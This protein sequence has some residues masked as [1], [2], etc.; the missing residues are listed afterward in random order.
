MSAGIGS[1]LGLYEI[2]AL[3]GKGGMGEVYRGRDT[4]LKRDVAIKILP[5]EFSRDPDRVGRFQREA[6]VLASLNHPNIAAIYDLQEAENSRFL[7]LELVEGET[8][9]ERIRR[10]PLPVDEALHIAKSICEAVEA[11]HEKGIIHRDLKPANIKLT[12]DGKVKVLDFGLAKA[13]EREQANAALSNSPTISMAATNAGIILGTAAYMSPQQASGKM[14][15]KRSDL[16]A[17]GVVLMEMLTG[18]QVFEGETV[19]HVLAAVLAKEPD[20]TALPA[21]TPEPIRKLLRRCLEKDRKRRLDS[22][23]AARLDID[24]SLTMPSV[25]AHAGSPVQPGTWRRVLPWTIASVLL[26]GL[27]LLSFVHFREM[28]PATEKSIR[29]QVPLP[30]NTTSTMFK[31]SPDGRYLAFVGGRG[32]GQ[33]WVRAFDALEAKAIPGTDGASYP[34][35]SPDSASIGFFTEGKLKKVAV[36][37][38]PALTLADAVNGRGAAWGRSGAIVFSPANAGGLYRVSEMGGMAT[39]VTNVRDNS[40][41]SDRFPEFLPDGQHFLYNKRSPTPDASGIFIGS[42]DGSPPVRLLSDEST[43]VYA[44]ARDGSGYL[45]F[46]RESVLMAQP[47][48]AVRL[49]ITGGIFPVAEVVGEGGATGSG[50]FSAAGDGTLGYISGSASNLELAWLDRSGKRVSVVTK[51]DR[52]GPF[53]LSPDGKAI[54]FEIDTGTANYAD[55]WLQ[56]LARGTVSRFTFG[57]RGNGSPVWSPDGSRILFSANP[58]PT[59]YDLLEKTV[60]GAGN[61]ELILRGIHQN[62]FP[63]DWSANGKLVAYSDTDEKTKDDLWLLPMDGDRK[64]VALVHTPGNDTQGQF[65][66][67]GGWI[68]YT[69][70][71]SGR[72]E[73]YIQTISPDGRKVQ[74]S[75]E[76][77]TKPRW[78]RDGRELFYLSLDQK[79]MAVPVT[80]GAG[81]EPGTPHALFEDLLGDA[82][83]RFFSYQPSSDGQRFLALAPAEGAGLTVPP[84][85]VVTN[86]MAALKK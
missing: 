69:S 71:E 76:G 24:E 37:G 42:L 81:L 68:A 86:W 55:I 15:D 33:L 78:R 49:Q 51:P 73:I 9:A 21:K 41:E 18:R 19:S 36:S 75:T 64:P 54:A 35:W 84:I 60:R 17:F 26:L 14:V 56:D 46:R 39:A 7:V 79:L 13:Y 16:W 31:L 12:P 58:A 80:T 25:E 6:E 1:K 48:D 8:L 34:F 61:P 28:P 40:T 82:A 70:D 3:L 83:S 2:T 85:T 74:V 62:M 44:A 52:I 72:P 66:P 45:L 43:A 10:G 63:S 59:R 29:F 77:G 22:A 32:R 4:K 50:A 38:G 23:A 5:D 20:W 57:P 47:F 67:D 27:A 53:S 11:A 65:S 30:E